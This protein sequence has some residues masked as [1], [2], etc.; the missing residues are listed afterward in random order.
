ML[1]VSTGFTPF[2]SLVFELS[3]FETSV[4]NDPKITLNIMSSKVPNFTPF[5]AQ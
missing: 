1:A 2:C 4:P 3:Y 5:H